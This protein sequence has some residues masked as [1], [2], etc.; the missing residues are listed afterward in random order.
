[1]VAVYKLY[2]WLCKL[3]NEILKE[4]KNAE[5]TFFDQKMSFLSVFSYFQNFIF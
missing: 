1:M 3:E 2:I 5:I 4:A